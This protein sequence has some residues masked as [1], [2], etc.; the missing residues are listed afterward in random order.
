MRSASEVIRL[1]E[2]ADE[3]S[4]QQSVSNLGAIPNPAAGVVTIQHPN[5][6]RRRFKKTKWP[7]GYEDREDRKMSRAKDFLGIFEQDEPAVMDVTPGEVETSVEEKPID[8]EELLTKI[9]SMKDL[10]D[11]SMDTCI[12]T[13]KRA[14]TDD[15]I[16]MASSVLRATLSGVVS[17]FQEGR[18][19]PKVRKR[20]VRE[21]AW[22][23]T[24]EVDLC[25]NYDPDEASCKSGCSS[26]VVVAGDVC[27]YIQDQSVCDC[28]LAE[29]G[30]SQKKVRE[31]FDCGNLIEGEICETGCPTEGVDKGSKCPFLGS[32]MGCGC[33]Q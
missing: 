28:Y 9:S 8:K 31:Q 11:G 21:Q 18:N 26:E 12:A 3:D 6:I 22:L 2:D 17:G 5:R 25:A 15:E 19:K 13:I 33:Y 14:E 10:I 16:K 24:G 30:E 1:W 29:S 32:Q 23:D 27:P 7:W 20:E 4:S